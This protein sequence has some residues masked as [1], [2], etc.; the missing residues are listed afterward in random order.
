MPMPNLNPA[1]TGAI[2]AWLF[3][4]K[5][6][7][8]WLFSSGR[9]RDIVGGSDLVSHIAMA[10]GADLLGLAID[11]RGLQVVD[12]IDQQSAP[13]RIS[14]SRRAGGA[15]CVHAIDRD[16]LIALRRAFLL[17]FLVALPGLEYQD[18]FGQGADEIASRDNAFATRGA[19]RGNAVA[20]V[21]PLGRPIFAINPRSGLPQNGSVSYGSGDERDT[22]PLD[23][24]LEPLRRRANR[25]QERFAAGIKDQSNKTRFLVDGAAKR[26]HSGTAAAG[27]FVYPRNL[28]DDEEDKLGNP[29]FPWIEGS[30]DRRVALVHADISGLGQVFQNAAVGSAL[31][32]R[33][34]AEAIEK[35]ILLAVGKAADEALL[36]NASDHVDWGKI[37]PARPLV[38]GGD[39]IT[40]LVRADLALPFAAALLR[41]IESTTKDISG[42]LSAC[43]GIAI[44]SKS[45]PFLALNTLA[46]SLCT[47]AKAKA[48]SRPRKANGPW[49]SLIAFHVHS[50]SSEEE[51]AAEIH[52]HLC[53]PDRHPLTANPY[54]INDAGSH[55]TDC[56]GWDRLADL[57]AH[58]N[59][60]RGADGAFR[61]IGSELAK[62]PERLD[63]VNARWRRFWSRVGLGGLSQALVKAASV[64]EATIRD[65]VPEAGQLFD[66]LELIDL[67]V[68][69]PSVEAGLNKAIAV[70]EVA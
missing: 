59:A 66:A 27:V 6:I 21:L 35:A 63:N 7:Q 36:P 40:V 37:V 10:E 3:E 19:S 26:F 61:E 70:Q 2:H 18:A 20:S 34:L 65:A 22:V 9:L 43:A 49:P 52:P 53:P 24:V 28:A 60:V 56:T 17:R 55:A 23:R 39:D 13:E 44:A 12:H 51:Y 15:F 31:E 29:L 62:G 50:Q 25:L 58:I 47:F 46:E 32:A 41:H 54:A 45:Q 38:V 4:A 33:R 69:L 68:P 48:K 57:A 5:G 1:A 11:E 64:D 67:K 30:T 8:R 14:L 42:G 16:T